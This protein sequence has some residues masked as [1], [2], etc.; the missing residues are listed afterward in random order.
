MITFA[1]I[2]M[3]T[4]IRYTKTKDPTILKSVRKFKSKNGGSYSVK[5]NTDKMTYQINN[6]NTMRIMAS[7]EKDNV[8]PPKNLYTVQE[9]VKR[10]L[11]RLGVKFDLDLRGLK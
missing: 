4:R 10:A 2:K 6:V 7:T 8:K 3:A 9:Q 5:I 11:K 1:R